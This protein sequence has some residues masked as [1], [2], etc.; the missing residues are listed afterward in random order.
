MERLVWQRDRRNYRSSNE[1]FRSLADQY[2]D[3]GEGLG[4]DAIRTLVRDILGISWS[5][6]RE[7]TRKAASMALEQELVPP[8][9]APFLHGY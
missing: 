3:F 9:S 6:G 8:D 2:R 7:A 4:G 1:R 5:A